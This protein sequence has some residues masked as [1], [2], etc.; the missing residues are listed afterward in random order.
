MTGRT[1]GPARPLRVVHVITSLTTGGAERQL[2][3]LVRRSAHESVT[4]AL[5]AGLFR[6]GKSGSPDASPMLITRP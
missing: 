5:Y 6:T 1:E 4:I 3:M 2:E